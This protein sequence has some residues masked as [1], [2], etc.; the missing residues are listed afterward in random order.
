LFALLPALVALEASVA[1]PALAQAPTS[2]SSTTTT[3]RPATTTTAPAVTPPTS[4]PPPS[5]PPPPTSPPATAEPPVTPTPTVPPPSIGAGAAQAY[6]DTLAKSGASNTGDLLGVLQVLETLGFPRDE[7]VRM[8]FGRFP[9]GGLAS[10]RDDFGDPRF[11]P[12]PHP[13]MGNDIFAAFDVPVRAPV[14]GT[15]RFADESTGGKSAYVT[16]ADGTFY[17]MTHLS[18]FA[19]DVQSGAQVTHGQVVG[20]VGDSGNARG[21][22]P[23]VHFEIHPQGGAAVNP[24]PILD[25]WLAEAL[26]A[27]P[28]LVAQFVGDQPAV[29]QATG[30]TRRFDVGDHYGRVQPTVEPL[31]WA[32]AVSPTGSALRLAEVQAARVVAGIDWEERA[33]R[34]EAEEAEWRRATDRAEAVLSLLTPPVL[35]AVLEEPVP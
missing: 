25:A 22:A 10:F 8:G 28:A 14:D 3:V 4:P 16:T 12:E 2:T 24:K 30:L 7:V 18:S 32:S 29:L 27:A 35:A 11:T 23:H 26:A 13:H 6:V 19:P 33:E 15:L 5:S 20:A 1:A 9:V 34:I 31:L 21:S 17:Y